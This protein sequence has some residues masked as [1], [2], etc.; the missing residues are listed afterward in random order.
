MMVD[1]QIV[2]LLVE[3]PPKV[4]M[5]ACKV[6]RGV[7]EARSSVLSIFFDFSKKSVLRKLSS[8]RI[9]HLAISFWIKGALNPN[10]ATALGSLKATSHL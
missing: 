2:I 6:G 7:K 5:L 8:L 1:E 3:N 4:S 9:A 10:V